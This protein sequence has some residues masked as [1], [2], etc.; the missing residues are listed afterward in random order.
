[1]TCKLVA[2]LVLPMPCHAC[3]VL[4]DDFEAFSGRPASR[5]KLKFLEL[6]QSVNFRAVG[7]ATKGHAEKYTH[8]CP[9]R[10][11]NAIQGWRVLAHELYQT[12]ILQSS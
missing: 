4:A 10:I 5:R 12:C 2:S 11:R 1:M 3:S 9:G 8:A 6:G 7:V